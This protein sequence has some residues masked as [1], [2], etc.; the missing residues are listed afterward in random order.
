M[1]EKNEYLTKEKFDELSRELQELKT[2]KRKQVAESLEYA[3]S[4]G[5][6]S[7]NAEYHEARELQANTEDRIAK[8]ETMLK[9]A[10]IISLHHSEAVGIGSVVKLE[11]IKDGSKSKYKIVGSEEA[12]LADGKLSIHSP[13]GSTMVGKKK[14]DEFKVTTPGGVVEY[15]IT[16]IE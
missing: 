10:V 1:D 15:K 4:L 13:L 8:L 7:E 2:T 3:K 5:D 11:K 16:E 12:N 6:L 9:S 14:G